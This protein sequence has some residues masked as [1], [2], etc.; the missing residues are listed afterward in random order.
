MHGFDTGDDDD[1]SAAKGLESQHRASDP[2]NCPMVLFDDVVEILRL[3][4]RDSKTT[5]VLDA[6]DGGLVGPA[7]VDGDFLWHVV[8]ADSPF[9]ECAGRSMIALDTQ[10]KV[11]GGAVFCLL[12]CTD[13]SIR[14]Q[15]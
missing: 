5:V 2:F 10:Q 1:A 13:T 6:D 14:L 11:N 3:A 7:F 9:E 15:P 12:P 8:Q 4:H